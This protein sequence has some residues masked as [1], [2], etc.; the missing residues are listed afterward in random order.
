MTS[1]CDM[2]THLEDINDAEL[3]E[4]LSSCN[5]FLVDSEFK[6]GR[7]FVFSF[8]MSSVNNSFLNKNL[9]NLFNQREDAAKVNLAF[10]FVLKNFGTG[11]C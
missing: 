2:N 6:K 9:D 5:H 3:K 1:N 7:N 8:A 11:I 10:G 4:E